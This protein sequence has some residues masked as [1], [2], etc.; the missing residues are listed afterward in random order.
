MMPTSQ[1]LWDRFKTFYSEFPAIGLSIDLSRMNFPDDLFS[2]MEPR[3]QRAFAAM[4]ALEGGAI[5]N[6]DEKRMVGHYW[7]RNPLLAPSPELR[8]EIETTFAGIKSFAA[9]VHDASIAGARGRFTTL[10]VIGI[11]GSALGPQFVANALG[12]PASDKLE[13]FFFDNTDPDGMEKVLARI[14]RRLGK[15]LCVVISKSGGTQETRN[16]MPPRCRGHGH[17][18]QARQDSRGGPLAGSVPDVGLGWRTHQRD[19]RCRL[20]PRCSARD[21]D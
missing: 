13:P 8:G 21:Q 10:L 9:K 5:A 17:W 11:G 4:S 15:T 16:G 18:Q 20:A 19:F 12:K 6:P 2:S 1:Q 7:L 14:S 3:L